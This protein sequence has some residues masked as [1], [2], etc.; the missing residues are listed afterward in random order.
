MFAALIEVGAIVLIYMLLHLDGVEL[1]ERWLISLYC[2]TSLTSLFAGFTLLF[3]RYRPVV[4][5]FILIQLLFV[6][7]FCMLAIRLID[8]DD[9]YVIFTDFAAEQAC[10][11]VVAQLGILMCARL[12]IFV[13]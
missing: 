7:E 9:S 11:A 1:Q 6:S 8:E 2:L 4:Y 12:L 3:F 13:V 10:N 5:I